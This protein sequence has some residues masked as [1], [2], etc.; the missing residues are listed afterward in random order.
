MTNITDIVSVFAQRQEEKR[1][2]VRLCPNAPRIL[3]SRVAAVLTCFV[4]NPT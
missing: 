3:I 1:Q 2:S 4:L